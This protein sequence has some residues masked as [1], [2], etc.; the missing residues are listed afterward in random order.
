M[1]QF[2]RFVQGAPDPMCVLANDKQV[3]DL[4]RFCCDP[5]AFS[6]LGIDPTFNLGQFSVTV[7]TYRHLQLLDRNTRKPPVL[8]GPMLVHQR[9]TMQSYHF[10]ASSIVGLCPDLVK[11]NTFGTDGE[12]ALENAFAL[13][14]KKASHLLCFLH[15]KDSIVR[16]LREIGIC[17]ESSQSFMFDIFGKQEGTH[18]YT[19]LVDAENATEFDEQLGNLKETWDERECSFDP[20][21]FLSGSVSI[22]LKLFRTKC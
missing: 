12:K 2:T 10:L 15:V 17:G 14:F 8:L 7:T 19:G 18:R 21:Y 5:C 3:H 6:I 13:Q 9:K 11:L 1:D 4:K 16:K 22:K 20:L